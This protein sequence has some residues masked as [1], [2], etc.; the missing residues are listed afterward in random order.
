MN[1]FLV[2]T[3]L[4]AMGT[5]PMTAQEQADPIRAATAA[6]AAALDEDPSAAIRLAEQ[7]AGNYPEDPSVLVWLGHAYRRGNQLTAASAAYRRALELAPDQPEAAMG[8]A[9]LSEIVGDTASAAAQYDRLVQTV[10]DFAPA[11]RAAGLVQ[12]QAGNHARAAEQFGAYLARVPDDIE[13]LYLHGVA[14]YFAGDHDEAIRRLEASISRYPDLVSFRYALG[15]VL[16]DR[17][18]EAERALGHL[19][20]AADAGFEQVEANYLLGRVHADAGNLEA[21]VAAFE[22]TLELKPDHLD[23]TY[24]LGTALSRLGRREEA[25]PV[26]ARFGQL[27][28]EFNAAEAADKQ[29]KTARNALAAAL[30]ANDGTGALRAVDELL[31]LAPE[32]PDALVSA[33]KVWLSSGQGQSAFDA[34][35]AASQLDP[36][37]WEANY[38]YGLLLTRAERPDMALDPLRRSIGT[39]PLF[40]ETH[41][42]LG[43][44]FLA[45]GDAAAAVQSYLAAI[46]LESDNPGT[47]LNLA[48]AYRILQRPDLEQRAQDE[49]QRLIDQ[50]SPLD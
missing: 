31:A 32:D 26:M 44:A 48:V 34:L 40:P 2:A 7:A 24:R 22:R 33:A 1:I 20:A 6:I 49:Y 23:A 12:M 45:L 41:I 4:L 19:Q 14:L 21:A 5:L 27:Q 9:T 13:I 42:V 3:L 43:N 36:G 18:E 10:P 39:N 11:W 16:A 50:Q 29:V 28:Q 35:E 8:L 15:V 37:H 30:R 47:W 25:R 46:E 38:L 17:P